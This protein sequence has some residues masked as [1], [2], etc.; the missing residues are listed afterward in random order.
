MNHRAALRLPLLGL[1]FVA[2]CAKLEPIVAA[3]VSE[4]KVQERDDE[5]MDVVV[6]RATPKNYDKTLVRGVEIEGKTR[7]GP[8]YGD[9][10]FPAELFPVGKSRVK[11][12][13][14]GEVKSIAIKKWKPVD[15]PVEIDVERKALPPRARI[16]T[17]GGAGCGFTSAR[18]CITTP[19]PSFADGKTSYFFSGPVGTKIELQ[20][21]TVVTKGATERVM[22][23]FDFSKE[24]LATPVNGSSTLTFKVTSPDG[25]TQSASTQLQLTPQRMGRTL[26]AVKKGPL[27]FASEPMT[28]GP[29]KVVALVEP[30]GVVFRGQ[31]TLPQL[32]LVAFV[33]S[34]P[35][36][37]RDCGTYVGSKTGKRVTISNSAYDEEIVV[38]ERKT[39]KVRTRRTFRAD[40]P[41]CAASL[42]SEYT[43][44]KG[45]VASKDKAAF[46]DSLVGK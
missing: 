17:E 18:I 1:V 24:L 20:G 38:Y 45:V 35:A 44:V 11:V 22:A 7:V 10:M 40:M 33:E 21:K 5:K 2:G 4:T 43:G 23:P 9:A 32:E 16:V 41:A 29:S 19:N 42:S 14:K 12:T 26:D 39:G 15:V 37:S 28:V 25:I 8:G 27:R 36:R 6:V 31:G 3:E 13:V 46:A 30:S 34:L